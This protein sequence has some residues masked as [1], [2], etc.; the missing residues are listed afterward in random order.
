M[1]MRLVHMR[2]KPQ[3]LARVQEIYT[4]EVIPALQQVTGCLYAALI[5]STHQKDECVS[6]TMWKS[7]DHAADYERSGVFKRLLDKIRPFMAESSEWRVQLSRDFNLEYVPV[8]E[9]PVV[10]AFTVAAQKGLP[11]VPQQLWLRIVSLKIKPGMSAEFEQIYRGTVLP[12]LESVQGCCYVF[13]TQGAASQN[14][15]LSITLWD[16]KQDAER[17]EQ[18]GRFAE[19][20]GKTKHTLSELY[21]WKMGLGSN[22]A[23]VATSED[24]TAEH[25]SIMLGK[26]F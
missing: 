13:L 24:V 20:L 14:E 12:A 4:E 23:G 7:P 22:V 15:F 21:R 25:Y 9:E 18:S 16:S 5:Q 3:E 1:Y 19:L 8:P 10:K 26:C 17:Y 2:I 11:E 6:M